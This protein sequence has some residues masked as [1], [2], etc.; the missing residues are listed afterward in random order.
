MSVLSGDVLVAHC[1]W[2]TAPGK[3]WLAVER[4]DADGG[5]IAESSQRV[6]DATTLLDRL[7]RRADGSAVL[8][9]FDFPIGIPNA[10][11]QRAGI[12]AFPGFLRTLAAGGHARF[13]EAAAHPT[14][15]SV[16]RPFC[17][18][19]PGSSKQQHL[20]EALGVGCI[21]DLRRVC[22]RP[23]GGRRAAAPL[24][25]L[26]GAAQVGR[27]ALSGWRE[28]LIP[29]VHPGRE[30]RFWPFDGELPALL[31]PGGVV[32]A[33]TYPAEFYQ[34]L[35]ASPVL[36]ASDHAAGERRPARRWRQRPT[37]SG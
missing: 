25:W 23:S 37:T 26:V 3:Q 9:G 24:F 19:A 28:V 17:P 20:V 11:A 33:E 12:E 13:F 2:S 8:V 14:G 7:R 35:Q 22:E 30:V 34:H 5:A 15:I 4:I 16:D 18:A 10:Y 21:D 27:A 36:E 1:D 31:V 29:A 6:G 32:V